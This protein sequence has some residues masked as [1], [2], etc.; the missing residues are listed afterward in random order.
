M[1][2][3]VQFFPLVSGMLPSGDLEA[4]DKKIKCTSDRKKHE[5][6]LIDLSWNP[7]HIRT[8]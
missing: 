8:V 7:V 6:N 5:I 4:T 2:I 1:Q 3:F